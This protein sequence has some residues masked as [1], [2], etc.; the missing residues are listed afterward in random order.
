MTSTASEMG[1][2]ELI[3]G[4]CPASAGRRIAAKIL[5]LVVAWATWAKNW[6]GIRAVTL[7]TP[8]GG[9]MIVWLLT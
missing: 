7:Y 4:S 6:V 9:L 5:A 3:R 2:S 8:P 1:L